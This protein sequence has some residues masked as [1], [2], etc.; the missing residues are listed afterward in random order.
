MAGISGDRPATLDGV[1]RVFSGIQP[2]GEPHLGNFLGM[3]VP[4]VELQDVADAIY[5]VVDLHA[6]TAAHD[7]SSFSRATLDT[8]MI[9]LAAGL[10]PDRSTL[11]V[12]SHIPE[13]TEL[14]WMLNCVASFGELRRMTQFKEKS[15]GQDSVSVGLFDYPVLMAADI[16]LYDTHVVPVGDDQRQHLE[17]SRDLALRFNHRYGETFVVPEAQIRDVAARIMDLQDPTAKMSKSADSPQGTVLIL[18]PPEVV[19]KKIKSA[20]TDSGRDITYEPA[21]KPGIA[22]LLEIMTAV[23]GRAIPELEAEYATAGYGG[24]K[25]AV[26]DAVIER[27]R[28]V[29]DR[30]EKLAHDPA[31]VEQVLA[32]GATKARAIAVPVLTRAKRSMGLLDAR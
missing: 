24:F 10:E 17:L 23:T 6:L 12:Q 1:K 13:H 16:L 21:T 27:L 7:P 32:E 25:A 26:A 8:A 19:A 15:V 4:C 3:M 31:G 28:P 2:T 14:T 18:D 30:Y 20:V 9:L 5:C 11:F 29:R 22:N